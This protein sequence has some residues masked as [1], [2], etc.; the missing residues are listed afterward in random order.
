MFGKGTKLYSILRGKCPH[1]HEGDFFNGSF[2]KAEPKEKCDVCGNKFSKEPGFYQ[3]SYYV[4]YAL[5]VAIF[6]TI[7]TSL[8]LFL[9]D[10]SFDTILIS[11]VAGLVLTAPVMYPLSKIIWANFFFRYKQR[12]TDDS[13][14]LGHHETS[15]H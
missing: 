7:W 6:V 12:K 5:G 10:V 4:V 1:C 2:F 15:P 8:E 14:T 13:C 3:G 11:V 9:P